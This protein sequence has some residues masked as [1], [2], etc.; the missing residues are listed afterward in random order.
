MFNIRF[1]GDMSRNHSGIIFS[2]FVG[3]TMGTQRNTHCMFRPASSSLSGSLL[4]VTTTI[5]SLRWVPHSRRHGSRLTPQ[6]SV[7]QLILSLVPSSAKPWWVPHEGKLHF[8]PDMD[9]GSSQETWITLKPSSGIP[10]RFT[11]KDWWG[12]VH[13]PPCLQML[14]ARG[15]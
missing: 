1:W 13:R 3:K 5:L 7:H 10:L 11:W 9:S 12:F 2:D 14:T 15:S 4:I 6:P 8:C